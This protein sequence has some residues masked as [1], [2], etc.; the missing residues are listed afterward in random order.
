MRNTNPSAP[1]PARHRP[2]AFKRVYQ[3]NYA[4]VFAVLSRLGVE[5]GSVDDALQEVFLTAYRRRGSYD[6]SRPLKPWL[7]GIARK[8]A[9][10]HRR[11]RVRARRK[12]DAFSRW[13][14][15]AT[16][17][18]NSDQGMQRQLIARS[19]LDDFLRTLDPPRRD[20]FILAELEGLRGHEIADRLGINMNTAYTRLRA[21]R[22]Q[23]KRA[24]A[25]LDPPP[26]PR[27]KIQRAWVV[28]LPRL[29]RASAA[30]ANAASRP[31]IPWLWKTTATALGRLELAAAAIIGALVFYE[32][33]PAPPS[34]PQITPP[35]ARARASPPAPAP[36]PTIRAAS[37]ASSELPTR[38]APRR[39]ALAPE[40]RRERAVT[41]SPARAP[42]PDP[43]KTAAPTAETLSL[44]TRLLMRA[45]RQRAADPQRA[46]A[47]LAEH[48]DRYP[49][50]A[51]AEARALLEIEI[52]CSLGHVETARARAQQLTR[53]GAQRS[54]VARSLGACSKRA[55]PLDAG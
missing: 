16:D 37:S 46:L 8:V 21:A 55:P 13:R 2:R 52:T 1:S 50:G 23:L 54:L 9:F 27:A 12:L 39:A 34:P 44:E 11:G 33:T 38:A 22:L 48:R 31:A 15:D 42:R 53:S 49:N 30:L 47:T 25:E 26:Q 20:V 5:R 24:L 14:A 18:P 51:L 41:S 10:R 3:Q 36:A 32:P 35:I 17:D 6:A 29:D 45:Q 43:T 7:A 40:P 28:L 19:F 4:Y